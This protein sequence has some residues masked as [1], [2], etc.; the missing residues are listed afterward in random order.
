MNLMSVEVTLSLMVAL[1]YISKSLVAFKISVLLLVGNYFVMI[2]KYIYQEPHPFWVTDR[3][4]MNQKSCIHQDYAAPSAFIFNAVLINVLL[5]YNY[6]I[7]YAQF[8]EGEVI[9]SKLYKQKLGI[10]I[11]F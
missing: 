1:F 2:L 9:F 5:T 8:N 10:I 4:R 7:K 11:F 3:I 6:G